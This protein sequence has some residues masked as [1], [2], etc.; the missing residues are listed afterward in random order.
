V[1]QQPARPPRTALTPATAANRMSSWR[2]VAC[3]VGLLRV[4]ERKLVKVCF[5]R[6][7]LI[8]A[9][10]RGNVQF[11][12]LRRPE[13][14]EMEAPQAMLSRPWHRRTRVFPVRVVCPLPAPKVRSR[15]SA[16]AAAGS[17]RLRAPA[18]GGLVRTTVHQSLRRRARPSAACRT[19]VRAHSMV[20]FSPNPK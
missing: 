9:M 19:A 16:A 5:G 7:T 15:M 14:L 17:G 4:P 12:C 2:R 13:A 6:R 10:T 1:F 3:P 8:L 11:R 20:S 18:A